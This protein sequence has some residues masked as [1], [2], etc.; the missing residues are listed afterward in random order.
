MVGNIILP[1]AT[2]VAGLDPLNAPKNMA[3]S[4]AEIPKP[5]LTL[6]TMHRAQFT[7]LRDNPPTVMILA[8]RTKNGIDIKENL[9]MLLNIC[10]AKI[11]K[12]ILLKKTIKK[13]QAGTGQ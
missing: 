13:V 4:W 7:I 3:D 8:A 10:W 11:V 1:M 9:S 5:P 6:P 2:T 12:G